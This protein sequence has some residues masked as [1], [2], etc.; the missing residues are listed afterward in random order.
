VR[1]RDRAVGSRRHRGLWPLINE[2][3][4]ILGRLRGHG[5]EPPRVPRRGE[6][7]QDLLDE[8]AR[9]GV[10]HNPDDIVEIGRNEAGQVVFLERGNS[11]AGLQHIVERHA[12]DFANVGVPEDRIAKLVFTAVTTGK[13]VG[14]QRTR[15]IYE[16]VFEGKPYKLAVSISRPNWARATP[17]STSTDAAAR[18]RQSV[19]V[20]GLAVTAIAWWYPHARHVADAVLVPYAEQEAASR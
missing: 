13:A 3:K 1:V 14:A 18:A 15:P 16:V 12:G 19:D 5:D 6:S 20:G 4:K 7:R 17:S 8:L 10:K 11:R 9:T 2:L